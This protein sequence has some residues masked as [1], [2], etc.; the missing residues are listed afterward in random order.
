MMEQEKLKANLKK[1][2]IASMENIYCAEK[3]L[4]KVLPTVRKAAIT[5]ELKSAIEEH[6]TQ[7]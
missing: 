5:E 4:T 6:L 3:L 1:P 7:T 2:F